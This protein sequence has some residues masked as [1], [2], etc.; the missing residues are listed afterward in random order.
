VKACVL[1]KTKP[2]THIAIAKIVAQIKGVKAAFAV[3]GRTDVVANVDADELA[4]VSELVFL[5][6]NLDG[7]SETETLIG[8]RGVQG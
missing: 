3:L 1:I 7:V 5:I 4:D 6:G 2:G 8:M